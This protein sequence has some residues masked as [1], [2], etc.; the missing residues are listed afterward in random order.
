MVSKDAAVTAHDLHAGEVVRRLETGGHDDHVDGALD[1]VGVDDPG[2][3]HRGD[4]LGDEGHVL[5]LE[6]RVEGRSH[7]RSLAG[8][9]VGG[10]DGF[11]EVGAVLE[12]AVDVA[13]AECLAL[14]VRLGA[15]S[16]E[17]AIPEVLLQHPALAPALSPARPS[18][19]EGDLLFFGEVALALR[20]HPSRL[21]LEQVQVLDAR[22]DGRHH[23]GRRRTRADHRHDLACQ[24]VLVLPASGMELRPLE[25]LE[26]GPVGI[27][28]HVEEA[29]GA[30]QDV[31][32][33][34][35]PVLES[36][37]PDVAVVVPGRRLHG[38]AQ[39][40]VRPK[41]ELVD[42]LLEVLLQLGLAGVGAGPVMG[43]E[44]EAV[45]VRPDVDLSAGIGVVPPRAA[46]PERGL[47]DRER[48]DTRPLELHARR[49]PAEPGAHHHDPGRPG[50]AEQLL[51]GGLHGYMVTSFLTSTSFLDLAEQL[52]WTGS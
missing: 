29:H 15:R 50:R 49:D 22:L 38:D 31:A 35:R 48:G 5:L 4:G 23:L 13:P 20:Q 10:C 33:V 51:G 42:G 45:E 19:G 12:D 7:H 46:D 21:P 39:L 1:P 28:R 37:S 47:V 27:P 14:R 16:P 25:V 41:P 24:V 44:R 3:S 11:P 36:Q 26:A 2:G 8:V 9:R 30:H 52:D 17:G 40:Q 32:L 34:D 18:L 43:L 6:R